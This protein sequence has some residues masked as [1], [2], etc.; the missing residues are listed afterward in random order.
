MMIR[1]RQFI[2]LVGLIGVWPLVPHA[3]GRIRTVGFLSDESPALGSA[4]FQVIT[5]QLRE[6]GYEEGRNIGFERRFADGK[7]DAL[8]GLATELVRA[9]VDVI[10]TVGT[11]ATRAAKEATDT[12]P[13]I[14]SR[15]ADPVALGL[16]AQL[17][18][19][20]GNLTGVS[21]VTQDLAAKRLELLTSLIPGLNRVGVLLD[22][23]FPSAPLELSEIESAARQLSIELYP[24]GIRR[25]EELDAAVH[26]VVVQRGQALFVVPALLFTEQQQR[27]ADIAIKRRLP[28]M[29]SR[30]EHVEAGGLMSYGVNYSTMYARAATYVDKILKGAKPGD[31]PVEQPT[32]LELVINLKT[33]KALGLA[34]P[35]SILLRTDEVIE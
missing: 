5:K 3:Q 14:F 10:V 22:P 7:N 19:P 21:V 2:K 31:L 8:S 18:R 4:A 16:V 24:I 29:L 26:G 12:I 25:V 13:V 33:A 15:I 6:L 35:Q 27:V 28:A 11:S 30:R 23:T 20:E 34:I 32:K 17:G 1:R 9:R